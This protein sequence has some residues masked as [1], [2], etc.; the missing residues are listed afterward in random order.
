MKVEKKFIAQ[1]GPNNT[2]KIFDAHTGNLYR[3]INVGGEI[4][5]QP[6]VTESEMM[7]TVRCGGANLLKLFQLPSGGLKKTTPI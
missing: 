3:V 5:S 6:I 4:T 1:T 7:I 2:V